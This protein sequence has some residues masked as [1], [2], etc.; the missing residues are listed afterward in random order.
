MS[1]ISLRGEDALKAYDEAIAINPQLAE[2]CY[3]KGEALYKLERYEDAQKAQDK[4]IDIY[5]QYADV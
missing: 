3:N 4:A 2:A 1:F 5:P